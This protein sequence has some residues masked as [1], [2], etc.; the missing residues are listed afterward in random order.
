MD[1]LSKEKI[2]AVAAALNAYLN[3]TVHDKESYVITIQRKE[4][5]WNCPAF[6]FR[7]KI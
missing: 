4:T 7:K 5:A 6:S 1:S 2:A 3:D